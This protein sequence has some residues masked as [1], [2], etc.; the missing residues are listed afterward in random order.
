MKGMNPPLAGRPVTPTEHQQCEAA[1]R[2]ARA[3]QCPGAV[4]EPSCPPPWRLCPDRP[5]RPACNGG[6]MHGLAT[7]SNRPTSAKPRLDAAQCDPLRHLL[8]QPPRHFG[9]PTGRWTLALAAQGCHAHGLTVRPLRDA[10][11]RWAIQRV[12]ANGQRATHWITS[13][14]PQ[15]ARKKSGVLGACHWSR[16]TPRGQSGLPMQGG[17]AAWPTPPC[18]PGLTRS[19]VAWGSKPRTKTIPTPQRSPATACG[20]RIPMPCAVASWRGVQSGT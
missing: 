19:R 15:Y 5:P 18:T 9:K 10:T 16:G 8:P 2:A 12:G 1:R 20:A 7:R 14:E 17:G 6:G 11:R 3:G 4:R 13:P